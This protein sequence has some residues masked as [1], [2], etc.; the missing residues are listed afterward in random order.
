MPANL[1]P[2]YEK[3][4]KRHREATTDEERLAALREM[5]RA[6]P[7]HKGTEKMQ[8][9]LKRRISQFRK[10]AGKKTASK[11]PDP[12][13]I[14]KG[15]AGQVI[16]VGPPN[17]G[18]SMLAAA[19]TNAPVKVAD[20]PYATAVPLP[21]MW[22]YEDAQIQLID[23]PPVTADHVPA[24][25]MSTIRSSEAIC[26]VVDL[27]T[28]PLAQAEL[29]LDLLTGRGL[30]LRSVPR[31]QLDPGDRNQR[32]GLLVANKSDLVSPETVVALR[33]LYADRLEV[34]PVSAATGEGLEALRERVWQLL[35]VLRVYTK[36]PGQPPENEHPFTLPIGSTIEDLAREIHRELPETMRSARIWGGGRFD[37]QHVHRTE[38]LR[39]KDVV[40]IHE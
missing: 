6:I 7:K 37:G 19:T 34:W 15:G 31:A 28:E 30:V 1:T 12:F 26:I 11:G 20:Y 29:A 27:A 17:V 23:T 32:S 5:L 40:E 39:D 22:R 38:V 21:G 10:V 8:A 24:G 4:E 3:A 33:D 16:L 25:L 36:K 9:D 13:H 14:P 2:E 18:K 35:S